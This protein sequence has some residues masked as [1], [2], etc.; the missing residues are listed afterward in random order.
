[1]KQARK[2]TKNFS[3]DELNRLQHEELQRL[4]LQ[5]VSMPL[6]EE[7]KSSSNAFQQPGA[8]LHELEHGNNRVAIPTVPKVVPPPPKYPMEDLDLPPKHNKVTRPELQ[9]FTS[10][11]SR[12]VLSGRKTQIEG[13]EMASM[14]MLLEVWNTLNVQAEVYVLDSFVFDDFVDAMNYHLLDPACELLNEVH[15]AVLKLLVDDKGKLT[16]TKGALPEMVVESEDES[17]EEA[18]DESEVSTPLPDAPARSTRSRLSHVEIPASPSVGPEK[19]HRATEMLADRDWVTRL[20]ARDFEDGG[21]QVILVGVLHQLSQSPVYKARCEQVLAWLAPIDEDATAETARFQYA[22]MNINLRIS[23][24]QM[25]TILSIATPDVKN[26][27]EAC[28]DDMTD[29]RK[30]KIE[31]QRLRKSAIEELQ[32]KDRERRILLPDNMAPD[33]PEEENVD[34]AA[35]NSD[36]DDVVEVHMANSSD[37]E[38]EPPTNGRSLRRGNDRK[39]KREEEA[40]RAAE[41]KRK[42]AELA[43]QQPKQSK[44]FK[45]LLVEIADLN[46]Q[47][48]EHEEKIRECDTDLREANVQRTRVLGKDRFCNR[49]Y[50]FERNGQPFGGLPRSTTAHYGYANGRIWV[51]GP[52][53]MERQGFID[54]DLEEQKQYKLQFGQTVPERRSEE[55]GRTSLHSAQEWGF[56]DDKDRLDNLIAWLDERGEREKKLRR[57]LTDWRDVIVQYMEAHK[58][59]KDEEAAK[60][61]E[62]EDEVVSRISTRHKV[63][64]EQMGGRERCLKWRNSM[65]VEQIGHPHSEVA[66]ARRPKQR[67]QLRQ[68][69]VAVPVNRHGK[70]VT[71]QGW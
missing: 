1:M 47:I 65:A 40:A 63:L 66:V 69:G 56:Y 37:A 5:Q 51:Q 59:F 46:K 23:A 14:G 16:L 70:P 31:F 9:F 19:T 32:I 6:D 11:M 3:Q 34:P 39:R 53:D 10:E 54:R 49:Y 55:E 41:E 60:K 61:L 13:M 52:D 38:D 2:R 28:S 71:R 67:V 25:I 58:K 17:S 62:A 12:Y 21:W 45:K 30:R 15:C 26:F 44:E 43:K 4:Q 68:K 36:T 33:S 57:E 18:M 24:L 50:W 27:L 42:K 20:A 7:P 22:S 64:E 35:A 8:P 29:V 48:L